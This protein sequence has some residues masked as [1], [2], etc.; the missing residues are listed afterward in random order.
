MR[1]LK[2]VGRVF[3]VALSLC[4]PFTAVACKDEEEAGVTPTYIETPAAPQYAEISEEVLSNTDIYKTFYFDAE[5][6]EDAN[7]GLHMDMPKKSL[8]E[9][10]EII[11]EFADRYAIRIL[12]KRGTTFN[13][14]VKLTGYTATAEH[15]FIVDAYGEGNE[16]PVIYGNGTNS[17]SDS[18]LGKANVLHLEEANTRI[19][20]IEITGPDCTRG[21]YIFPRKGGIF[22]NIVVDGCYVHNVNWNWVYGTE[23]DATNPDDIDPEVVTPSADSGTNRFRRLYGGICIFTGDLTNSVG[24]PVTFRNMWITDNKVEEVA[25]LGINFYNYWVNRPGVGYGYN[26]YVDDTTDHNDYKTGVGYFPME[27]IVVTGNYTNCVGGDGIVVA[28]ADNV[29]L[30]RNTSYK[31]NYLG[32]AGFWNG[33]IWVHNVRTGYYQYNEAG[34]TYLR[35]GSSDGEGFDIDNTCENVYMQYNYGHHNEGGGLLL[36]N[37]ETAMLK[38]NGDGAPAT[39]RL[40]N[41]WGNWK[42]NYVRNNVFVNNGYV[43]NDKDD[44]N[45]HSA[46]V[47]IARKVNDVTFENNTV[48]IR[49][50]IYNQHIIDCEDNVVAEG[51]VYRNNIFY[52]VD[53]SAEPIFDL[54]TI[55]NPV[56]EN[57]LYYNVKNGDELY[58]E[59]NFSADTKAILDVDPQIELPADGNYSGYEK[60]F[61]FAAKNDVIYSKGVA[62]ATMMKYDIMGNDA[63]QNFYIGAFAKK[64]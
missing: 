63:T 41:Y 49:G 51:H 39:E 40:E 59:L 14:N 32:R 53:A 27:N 38:F 7:S 43:F 18:E 57:N 23:P 52:C 44:A 10:P 33:G 21:I 6:G 36:C 15:P 28:G 54:G 20:N 16:Y 11:D 17:S 4:I 13:E 35:H 5:D 25:H 2:R 1:F 9:I 30:E 22:E 61:L 58:S 48:V 34:Y 3:A 46:F 64:A 31:S 60:A 29:W 45:H 47:T 55:K 62:I 19:L 50:D 42:S 12:L 37:L 24:A 26:K 56:F 8:S